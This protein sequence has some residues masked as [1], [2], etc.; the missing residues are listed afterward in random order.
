[1]RRV[2]AGLLVVLLALPALAAKDFEATERD[3]ECLLNW[4]KVNNVRIF[5]AKPRLLRK[6]K[7]VLESGRPNRKYPVGTIIQLIPQEAMAK[8]KKSFNPDGNGWEFF[9]L[10][11]SAAGT[12]IVS[13]GADAINFIDLP[14]KN[15]HAKAA[16]FDFVCEKGH[17]CNPIPLTDELIDT[18]QRAD[19]R[20][21][22]Q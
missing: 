18:L 19:P 4:D 15:C 10:G 9:Q 3:F 21:P 5:N 17:G 6:A 2:A 11:V 22:P 8:R 13:R 20:C 7:R 16:T 12:T 1:M 14:C